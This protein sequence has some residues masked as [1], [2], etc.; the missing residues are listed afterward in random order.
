MTLRER[1][2]TLTACVITAVAVVLLLLL[3]LYGGIEYD[4]RKMAHEPVPEISMSVPDEEELLIEPE[5]IQDLGEPDAVTHDEPAPAV[6]G[7]PEPDVKDNVR[8]VEKGTNPKPS[9]PEKKKV[10]TPKKSTVKSTNPSITDEERKKVTSKTAKAFGGANGMRDG[11]SGGKG[12][13]GSGVGTAGVVSGRVF[14]GC[15]KPSVALTHT[16]TVV[17]DVT[18]NADGHVISA[19][20]RRGGASADIRSKCEAAARSAKWSVKQGAP[21]AKGTIT[22]TIT[23]R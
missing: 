14:K 5:L 12:A 8:K 4:G 21:N 3:L 15:P 22:F 17:V 9:P 11:K 1:K 16:V 10:D 6:K 7:A 23:P 13:G 19:R 20:A 18:I 2:D